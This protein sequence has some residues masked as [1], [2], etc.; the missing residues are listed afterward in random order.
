VRPTLLVHNKADNDKG[1]HE[2]DPSSTGFN[3]TLRPKHHTCKEEKKRKKTKDNTKVSVE[4]N[5]QA[6][7]NLFRASAL[8]DI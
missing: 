5:N 4:K 3:L 7:S 8:A 1:S 6:Q 2:T